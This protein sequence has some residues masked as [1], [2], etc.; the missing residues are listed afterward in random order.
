[1]LLGGRNGPKVTQITRNHI[2]HDDY[3]EKDI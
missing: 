2:Y 3:D 1:M